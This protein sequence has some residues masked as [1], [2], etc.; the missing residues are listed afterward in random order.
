[1]ACWHLWSWYRRSR[2]CGA[3]GHPMQADEAERAVRCPACGQVSYPIIAPA[4]IVAITKG[5]RI[6]LVKNRRS[7]YKH[8]AL[9]SGYVEVGETLEHAVRR[10]VLEEVGLHLGALRYLGDQPWGVSG[11]QMFAF[12]AE[13]I[14]DEPIVMQESEL[15]SAKWFTRAELTPREHVVSIAMALIERFRTQTL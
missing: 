11:S 12:H 10:E 14:G 7:A 5:D 1:M 8:Y 2:F 9:V 6:L 15:S 3:C 4:V 13:A